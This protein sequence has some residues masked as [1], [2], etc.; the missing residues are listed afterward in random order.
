[1]FYLGFSD[2]DKSYAR[3]CILN[4]MKVQQLQQSDSEE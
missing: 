4:A 2:T 3:D 1:L